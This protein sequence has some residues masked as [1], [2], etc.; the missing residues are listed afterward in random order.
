MRGV[1]YVV[2]G[3]YAL[4]ATESLRRSSDDFCLIN[5]IYRLI[6]IS[7]VRICLWKKAF[8]KEYVDT[9]VATTNEIKPLLK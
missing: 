8:I 9:S 5:L 7:S 3:V 2:H 4:E 6:S 1:S